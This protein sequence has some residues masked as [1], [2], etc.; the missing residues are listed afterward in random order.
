MT[1]CVTAVAMNESALPRQVSEGCE[2]SEI[3]VA[4]ARALLNAKRAILVD[5]REGD[6]HARERIKGSKL[7]PISRFDVT[8]VSRWVK[9]GQTVVMQCKS[10]KRAADACRISVA[11]R[12]RG[13]EVVSLKGG[14]EAWKSAGYPVEFDSGM[15]PLS[16]M[17]Q[18]QLIIGVA[19]IVG[20]ALKWFAHSAFVVIP[21]FFG[22]GLTYAGASGTC[23]LASVLSA[24]PWNRVSSSRRPIGTHS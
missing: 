16:V 22:L 2:I 11:L 3:E 8:Q 24:M 1:A 19:I 14:I 23:G 4:S 17:R 20:A 15:C 18:V 9:P 6:E 7:L 10:G 12:A 13:I 5:V 21:A